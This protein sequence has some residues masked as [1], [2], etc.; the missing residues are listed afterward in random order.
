[1][2]ARAIPD[3]LPP[4]TVP[5]ALPDSLVGLP[6]DSAAD[7]AVLEALADLEFRSLD[8]SFPGAPPRTWLDSVSSGDVVD[9]SVRLFG[10]SHGGE[11]RL[12]APTYDIDVVSFANHR[13]VQY[14]V[15]F[16]LGE[17]RDR[18]AI[19][20]SR[21]P[22]YEG[23]IRERLRRQGVPEDLVYLALIE[24]GFSNTAVSRARAVGMWQ[25]MAATGR[26]YGL[27]QDA[28]LDQRRDPYLATDAAA[29]HLADL[30]EQ[31]GSWYLAAAAYNAGP[32]RV[33]RGLKRISAG[34]SPTDSTFFELSSGRY[35]RPETRDYVPK[36]I[37]AALIAKD[38]ARYGF[39][40]VAAL[41]PLTF[42]EVRITEATG[43]DVLARLADTTTRALAELNPQFVRGVTPPRRAVLVR[44][45]AG[46]GPVVAHRWAELPASERVSFLEHRVARGET[47]SGIAQRYRV[48]TS[49]LMAAN[50]GVKPT[51]LRVGYRLTVPLSG[52][53]RREASAGR[54]PA[55][56]A[57]VVTGVSHYTVRPGDS[58]WVV[59]QRHGVRVADLRFWNDMESG[60]VL[61]VGRRLRVAAP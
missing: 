39:D 23:M 59:A 12:A 26:R 40:S 29:R 34:D 16:F 13:R 38:P 57:A 55:R 6:G 53:A 19:W 11:A 61:Q 51:R 60:E 56:S 14:Y 41:A 3:S 47:L 17:A 48:S 18:F 27:S 2:V 9:E 30:N 20:L 7:R 35:L 44:V 42:D 4:D 1:V 31:F 8:R 45:P 15:D 46:A 36:L 10:K 43:L 58:L 5:A 33:E 22:R 37:A 32:T 21:L 28:W 49:L 24:S 25:F 52:A 54:A 50:P